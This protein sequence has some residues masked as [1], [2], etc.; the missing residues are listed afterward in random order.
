MTPNVGFGKPTTPTAPATSSQTSSEFSS[1]FPSYYRSSG[2]DVA[3]TVPEAH[4]ARLASFP[5][6]PETAR[7][8]SH[9]PR[10]RFGQTSSYSL[11]PGQHRWC[12]AG[13]GTNFNDFLSAP[14]RPIWQPPGWH[15]A[16]QQHYRPLERS[17]RQREALTRKL[18]LPPLAEAPAAAV[19]AVVP[20]ATEWGSVWT[21]RHP[22][23]AI[24]A[25][26]NSRAQP[27]NYLPR[28]RVA[29]VL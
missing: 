24:P 11:S 26:Q 1:D 25:S 10:R 27:D 9:G 12:F 5:Q 18:N 2:R 4:S 19:P 8:G 29:P 13:V 7:Q 14:N 15:H 23:V 28:R 17:Q 6:P 3:R 22:N 20:A 21:L 16:F